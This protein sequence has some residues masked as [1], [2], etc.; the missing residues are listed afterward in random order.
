MRGPGLDARFTTAAGSARFC[1]DTALDA[2]ELP[3]AFV[4]TTR[5]ATPRVAFDPL[6]KRKCSWLQELWLFVLLPLTYG[7]VSIAVQDNDV[8]VILVGRFDAIR[9]NWG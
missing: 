6:H 3:S 5:K 1:T 8:R 2:V 4:A 7:T 9:G